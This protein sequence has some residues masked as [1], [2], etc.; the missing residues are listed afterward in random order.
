MPPTRRADPDRGRLSR[1]RIVTAAV[2]LADAGG[3]AALSMR[4]LA[5]HL[6]FEV[7]SLYNHVASRDALEAL[8]VDAVAA[9]IPPADIELDPIAAI[10]AQAVA[11]HD[12][13]V[14]HPWC[15]EL[16][17]V[18]LPGPHRIRTMEDLLALFERSGFPPDL[19]HHGF[20]AVTNHVLGY[21]IQQL[22]LARHSDLEAKAREFIAS[23]DPVAHPRV[24]RHVHQHLEGDTAPSF[25][26]VLDLILD[27]LA[28]RAGSS[29]AG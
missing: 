27:G 16:W 19:A 10:R 9:E 13:L 8:M 1:E 14:A 18:H 21:T 20:H 26:L 15:A 23:V 28:R 11:T 22:G 4:E 7:M 24:L 25:E 6:G 17:L 12:V 3:L 5:R 29:A 2:R